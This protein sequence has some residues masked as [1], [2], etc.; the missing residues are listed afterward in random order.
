MPHAIDVPPQTVGK[1]QEIVNLVADMMGVPS[2]L[3]MRTRPPAIEVLVASESQGNPYEAAETAPLNSGLYCETVMSEQRLLVVPD[4]L[5][6]DAWKTN[7]DIGLGMIS[8]MGLPIRWPDGEVF[9]TICVLDSKMNAYSDLFMRLLGLCRDILEADLN[10]LMSLDRRL[11]EHEAK[12]QRL[13]DADIIGIFIWEIDTQTIIEANDAFLRIVGYDRDDVAA[14]RLRWTA[15]T[16]PEWLE[17][18]LSTRLPELKRAGR[19]QPFEKEY[20]HKDGHR[21]PVLMGVA[22]YGEEGN[23]AVA[24]M[25]DQTE[26]KAAEAEARES[27]RRHREIQVA[28]AH[29]NRVTTMGQ[30][31][32]SISHQLKQPISACAINADAG[33]RWLGRAAPD[34]EEARQAFRRIGKNARTAGEIMTHIRELF[35]H[36]PLERQPVQIN[37]AIR[38]VMVLT[39]AEA[40]R[41]EVTMQADLAADLPPVQGDRIQLQQAILNL[42][43]NAMEAMSTQK[44]GPRKLTVRTAT[45]APDVVRVTVTDTGP[46][47]SLTCAEEVFEPFHTS[48]EHGM[49]MGLAIC[50]SIV[51]AH[52]GSLRLCDAGTPGATF[53][54]TLRT[55]PGRCP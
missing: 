15:L 33:L 53:E 40:I 7:P 10:L 47:V 3:I 25:L 29:A 5:Q 34:L 14:R 55:W 39:H 20:V 45:H 18:D 44:V 43:V 4:A 30:L 27:D 41:H 46:G 16:P 26:R 37:D 50:R 21:I 42:L 49:G 1:W 28:L 54:F 51:E 32:A 52:G 38:D 12:I 22:R 24:F 35:K 23:Q 13:V 36:A 17:R 19:L 2:A 6:D 11:H 48:K 9:G 8:Y 31:T